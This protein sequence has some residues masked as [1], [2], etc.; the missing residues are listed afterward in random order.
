ML[1]ERDAESATRFHG[2]IEAGAAGNPSKHLFPG[3]LQRGISHGG[4][5]PDAVGDLVPDAVPA[6]MVYRPQVCG[7]EWPDG[8]IAGL[9]GPGVVPLLRT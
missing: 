8:G 2:A 3:A 5:R 4:V 6:M 9:I 7:R 1:H